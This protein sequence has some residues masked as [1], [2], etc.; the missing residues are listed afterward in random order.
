M[1]VAFGLKAHSGW[2]ALIVLGV[3]HGELEVVLAGPPPALGHLDL[4][5]ERAAPLIGPGPCVEAGGLHVLQ[6][7]HAGN[8][9]VS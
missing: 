2:A 5:A 7:T 6:A 8:P 9:S 4:I 1:K 3:E